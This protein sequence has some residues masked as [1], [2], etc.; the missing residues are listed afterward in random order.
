[1]LKLF[2]A[3]SSV[4]VWLGPAVS[5]VSPSA[6][7]KGLAD[8]TIGAVVELTVRLPFCTMVGPTPVRLRDWALAR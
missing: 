7:V 1:V 2:V 5:V 3:V 6:T 4:M 8:C